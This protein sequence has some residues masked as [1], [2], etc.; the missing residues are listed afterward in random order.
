MTNEEKYIAIMMALGKITKSMDINLQFSGEN[1]EEMLFQF[2]IECR[3]QV[4]DSWLY[5]FEEITGDRPNGVISA[6]EYLRS[7][8]K[9]P[10]I[11]K[12]SMSKK[13]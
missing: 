8:V 11:K 2:A 7:T 5:M 3:Q 4:N 12:K 6:A 10:N 13:S 1:F 9:T